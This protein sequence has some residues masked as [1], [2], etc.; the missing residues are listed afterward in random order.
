MDRKPTR[1]NAKNENDNSNTDPT[2]IGLR[3]GEKMLLEPEKRKQNIADRNYEKEIA[4]LERQISE[5]EREIELASAK[6]DIVEIS[7]LGQAHKTTQI[8]LEEAWTEWSNN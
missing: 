6:Q 8:H 2:P 5:I 7:R 4:D 3:E 1:V